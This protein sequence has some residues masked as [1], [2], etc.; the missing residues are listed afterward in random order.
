[1]LAARTTHQDHARPSP[2][3]DSRPPTRLKLNTYDRQVAVRMERQSILRQDDGPDL[4]FILSESALRRNVGDATTMR[5][6]LLHLAEV[7][8]QPNVTLQVFPFNAQTYETASFSFIILRF[9]D[10]AASDV[11]YV[12]TFTDAD[13][14]DRPDAVRAYTRLWDRLRA[15]ALGPVESRK[16]ILGMADDVER[17]QT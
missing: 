10:D 12:E 16:L 7:S 13:Y 4:S 6:Q 9:G 5:D 3:V 1:G 2:R 14:L 8:E 15:A 17:Q 11:I